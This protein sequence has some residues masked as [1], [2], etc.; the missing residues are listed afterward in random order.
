MSKKKESN[1]NRGSLGFENYY[2]SLFEGSWNELKDA[3]L[4]EPKYVQ[5]EYP[6]C[7]PYFMDAASVCAALCLPLENA[8]DVLDLCAAPG[9]KTIILSANLLPGTCLI[10]NERSPERKN[11][12]CKVVSESIPES[13]SKNIQIKC[14]DG[15][16]WCR[17]E[18]DCFDSILLDAPCSSERHV[19][20]DSKYLEQWSPARI[21]TIR[22]EQ[23]SLLSCAW[24]LLRKGGHLLYSTCAL[25]PDENDRL[26]SRLFK[27]FEDSSI[28]PQDKIHSI[29]ENNLKSLMDKCP[30]INGMDEIFN[31]SVKTEFGYH[32]L[33]HKAN[34]SGPIYY[35][36]LEKA[37]DSE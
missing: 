24:R 12:L 33:P 30:G 9:G 25:S 27:K 29:F 14:S 2:S 32:L 18:T 13:I 17:K 6:D 35:S 1:N 28:V 4:L 23:W 36:L 5:V 16:T 22:M 3:L 21:K 34:G 31:A 10:S 8:N 11:R 26:V 37:L 20:K 19:L 7:R 15:S